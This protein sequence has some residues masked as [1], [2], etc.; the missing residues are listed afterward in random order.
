MGWHL[1]TN[2]SEC[3]RLFNYNGGGGLTC[4]DCKASKIKESEMKE[5]LTTCGRCGK[6]CHALELTK[7]LCQNCVTR[8]TFSLD[9]AFAR[10]KDTPVE[11][12][13]EH[14]GNCGS[15]FNT[16]RE[17]K[18]YFCPYCNHEHQRV[19][20]QPNKQ[21]VFAALFRLNYCSF[22]SPTIVHFNLLTVIFS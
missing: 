16:T 3:H 19:G 10:A 8:L 12:V 13:T 5:H 20:L 11:T 15:R 22:L 18:V 7:G 4:A 17:T 21:P 9:P 14:C 1:R 2:C 6:Q